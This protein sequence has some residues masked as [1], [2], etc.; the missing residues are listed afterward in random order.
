MNL[1]PELLES[2]LARRQCVVFVGA[3]FSMPC[4]M[5]GWNKL[6]LEILH[7]VRSSRSKGEA[8]KELNHC[9]DAIAKG[10]LPEASTILKGLISPGDYQEIMTNIFG[11]HAFHQAPPDMKGAMMRRLQNLVSAPWAGILTTNY[12]ELIEFAL[13]Q[14]VHKKVIKCNGSN[15]RLGTVLSATPTEGL[16]FVKIHGAINE[17]DMVLTTADYSRVYLEKESIKIFLY[18]LMLRYHVVFIGCSLEDEI[19]RIRR[20]LSA[21]FHGMIPVAYCLMR[22]DAVLSVKLSS[23]ES[24]SK[25]V[26]LLYP[27][28]DLDHRS[29]DEC[30]SAIATIKPHT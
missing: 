27:S 12:D 16:F 6:L 9:E 28:S 23:L 13:D 17:G 5:P 26:P 2:R 10:M 20:F 30:L 7:F 24:E 19:V 15:S 18:S 1:I 3:G 8:Y 29:V 25:I 14:W 22:E 4:G 21:K 11:M